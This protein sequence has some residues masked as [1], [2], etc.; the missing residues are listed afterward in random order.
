MI[1]LIKNMLILSC[2]KF[3]GPVKTLSYKPCR[4]VD[5]FPKIRALRQVSNITKSKLIL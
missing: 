1:S 2:T 4:L 5:F 3:S